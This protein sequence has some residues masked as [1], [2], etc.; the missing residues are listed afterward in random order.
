[1][2]SKKQINSR[3][4]ADGTDEGFSLSALLRGSFF[5]LAVMLIISL[6]FIFIG[7][8]IAY[9]ASDP[10]VFTLPLSLVS[11]YA[12]VFGGSFAAAKASGQNKLLIG[13]VFAALSLIVTL[14]IK[15][16]IMRADSTGIANSTAYLVGMVATAF[17]ASLLSS[18]KATKKR[19]T[20][21][22]KF[23]PKKRR[24]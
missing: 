2:E 3:P 16:I 21:R 15:L 20:A 6:I 10:G 1:M 12:G 7:A 23:S 22:K 9:S 14:L 17:L 13:F 19:R 11:L 18:V 4:K 5:G 24:K 8:F